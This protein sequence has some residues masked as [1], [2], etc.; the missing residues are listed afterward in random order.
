MEHN[1][2]QFE[3]FAYNGK[4]NH[5]SDIERRLLERNTSMFNVH[6]I[7]DSRNRNIN[8]NRNQRYPHRNK[9][10]GEITGESFDTSNMEKGMPMRSHVTIK[11]SRQLLNHT[12]PHLDFDVYDE[13]QNND[14]VYANIDYNDP[15]NEN[16]N[17]GMSTFSDINSSS[18]KLLPLNGTDDMS[19]ITLCSYGI[20]NFSSTFFKQLQSYLQNSFC[21]SPFCLYS[22]LGGLY[23]CSSGS[24]QNSLCRYMSFPDKHILHDGMYE[25]N[26][27]IIKSRIGIFKNIL[28]LHPAYNVNEECCKYINNLVTVDQM[29]NG[30]KKKCDVINKWINNATENNISSVIN[31]ST[32]KH[33]IT[34]VGLN[35]CYIK[36]EWDIC[37]SKKYSA[38]LKFKGVPLREIPSLVQHNKIM[39]YY[40]DKQNQCIEIPFSN[41]KFTCGIIMPHNVTVPNVNSDYIISISDKFRQTPM[42]YVSIPKFRHQNKFKLKKLLKQNGM[43]DIFSNLSLSELFIGNKNIQLDDIIH[44]TTFIMSEGKQLNKKSSNCNGKVY[45]VA[46]H[47][48]VYYVKYMPTNTIILNGIFY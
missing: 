14:A 8:M 31:E 30:L 37:F 39:S 10:M 24:S 29:T 40:Q 15:I 32:I 18:Q 5:N 41:N 7:N 35:I 36:P 19:T 26:M 48:F 9:N 16:I 23:V 43:N 33:N 6:T 12:N 4:H 28:L 38:Q 11:K 17:S 34:S 20:N 45:F 42:K 44:T 27:T 22:F 21:I 3:T 1:N 13:E 2:R 46:D 25:I 47:P